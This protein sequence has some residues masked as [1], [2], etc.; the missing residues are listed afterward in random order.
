MENRKKK[1]DQYW[2]RKAGEQA[3]KGGKPIPRQ[4]SKNKQRTAHKK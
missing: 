3:V 4:S 2:A 1:E